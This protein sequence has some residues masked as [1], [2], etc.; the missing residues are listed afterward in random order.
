MLYVQLQN[1]RPL[2]IQS[3]YP[4]LELHAQAEQDPVTW[5]AT[6]K[7]SR[8]RHQMA[9]KPTGWVCSRD[10][11]DLESVKTL[12]AYLTAMTGKTYLGTDAGQ[13]CSPRYDVVEVPQV[14]DEVSYY[15]NGDCTPCGKVSRVSKGCRI[16]ETDTGKKFWRLRETGSWKDGI[17]FLTSGHSYERNPHL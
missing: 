15:F 14:G 13:W 16:V 1:G 12:A 2:K 5:W 9:D 4:K 6:P 10:F 8:H 11:E 7:R 17:W 3:E